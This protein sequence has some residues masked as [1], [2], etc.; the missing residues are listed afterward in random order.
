MG[1]P[2][3]ERRIMELFFKEPTKHWHFEMILKESTLSRSKAN[4]W[5][6]R[7]IEEAIIKRVKP[8]GKMPYYVGNFDHSS[9]RSKKKLYARTRLVETGFIDHLYSL[10]KAKT[11]IIFGSF[12]RGDWY[13]DSDIDVFIYGD[14]DGLQTL[15]YGRMLG[16]EIQIFTARTGADLQKMGPTL[17]RNIIE[18]DIIKGDLD[19]FTVKIN[20]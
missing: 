10:Q 8:R 17:I 15:K 7:L 11:V 4:K 6:K 9:Y 18:G 20:A 19:F 3:K 12:I 5:L 2:S 1:S 16:H 13:K 14:D